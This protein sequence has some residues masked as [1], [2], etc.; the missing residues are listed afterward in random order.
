L[1]VGSGLAKCWYLMNGEPQQKWTE[2]SSRTER[3]LI[4]GLHQSRM[5]QRSS[6][7]VLWD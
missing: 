7:C 4:A 3:R 5:F 6:F 1:G 2:K